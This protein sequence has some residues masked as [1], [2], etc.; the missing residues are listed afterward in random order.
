MEIHFQLTHQLKGN[1]FNQN[2]D[3]ILISDDMNKKE[4]LQ[5]NDGGGGDILLS[6][7]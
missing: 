4:L 2:F 5:N 7:M 3:H 6:N 1:E